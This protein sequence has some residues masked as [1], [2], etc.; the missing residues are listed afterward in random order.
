MSTAEKIAPTI[1]KLTNASRPNNVC[2]EDYG[3]YYHT[4]NSDGDFQ[5][6][7]NPQFKFV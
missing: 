2:Q 4:R 3:L 1:Y 5:V 7:S 6:W